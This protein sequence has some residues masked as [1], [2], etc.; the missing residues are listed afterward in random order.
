MK[1]ITRISVI[2]MFVM[3]SWNL[4]SQDKSAGSISGTEIEEYK[5]QVIQLVKYLEGTLNFL[6]DPS[7]VSREKET[8]INSSYDKIFKD[9]KV[10]VEDD[11]DEN[12][13]V[14]LHKDVQAYLK[15]IEFFFKEV[16]FQ[17]IIIDVSHFTNDKNAHFFKVTFNRDLN[18]ITVAGDSVSSRKVRYMEINVNK[19]ENDLKIASIYTTKINELEEMKIWWNGLSK[20]WREF[21][22][23]EIF[24][25]D[26]IELS[27]VDVISDSLI[28]VSP[29][30]TI[31]TTK[32]EV[33]FELELPDDR[34]LSSEI[35]NLDSVFGN[36]KEVYTRLSGIRKLH[37]INISASE[38]IRKLDPL[39]ELT[40]LTQINCSNTLITSLFPLRNL[41]KLEILNI[42]NTPIVDITPLMYSTSLIELNCSYT[43]MKSPAGLAGLI[44][45]E[46]LDMAGLRID[47][48]DFIKGLTKLKEVNFSETLLMDM[49]PFNELSKLEYLDV[50]QTRVFDLKEIKSLKNLTFLNCNETTVRSLAPLS[51]MHKL[52]VL[53]ISN[54]EVENLMELD[55]ISTLK[56]IYWDV[57]FDLQTDPGKRKSEAIRFMKEHPGT[58]VIFE[59]EALMKGWSQLEEPWKK[60]TTE[61]VNLPDNPGVEDLHGL[62]KIEELDLENS[63]V[64]TLKPIRQLYN[65][66]VLNASGIN[67]EDYSPLSES[68]ELENLNISN[69]GISDISFLSDLKKLKELNVQKYR[70]YIF[71]AVIRSNKT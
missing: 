36:T 63:G 20:P 70:D 9:D 42:S 15:D 68:F 53:K 62:L 17:F 55:S 43:L 67:I 65:L 13:E 1:T 38:D 51:G 16:S 33:L 44:N 5:A 57:E 64:T 14:P 54:T 46:K 2:T 47:N 3:T 8:I 31:D 48:F 34:T 61:A 21:F 19:A 35:A 23:K 7:S 40:E 41:N 32:Q 50:S 49:A 69:T 52:E 10:Q 66:K 18:G 60:V 27:R 4:I 30:T 25:F 26:S 12:R 56:R 37:S 11:L 58:L 6:G 45:L 22:G 28:L 59:S 39:S 24:I 71:N 29:K